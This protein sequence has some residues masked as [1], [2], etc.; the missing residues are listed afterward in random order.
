MIRRGRCSIWLGDSIELL[1]A[2]APRSVDAVITDPPYQIGAT[3]VGNAKT[4]AGTWVDMMNSARWFAEWIGYSLDALKPTGYLAVC[5]NWRSLPTLLRAFAM[6]K[7]VAHS[8]LVWD[9]QWIGP[10][11]AK[12]LRPRYE[13]VLIHGR[14]KARIDDRCAADIF[15]HKWQAAHGSETDH[16][17]EK[18]VALMAR[19]IELL[20]PAGGL[21]LDP[22]LGSGTTAVAAERL[23]RRCDGIEED[24]D[25]FDAA[26]ARLRG[27]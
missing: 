5:C 12:A 21:V 20:T 9:K 19:L 22:F 25:W 7:A 13:M 27:E 4:K 1:P 3:S 11:H 26:A 6:N 24:A 16:P 2:W 15:A 23:G 8:C 17:A 14:E 10:A 18:P